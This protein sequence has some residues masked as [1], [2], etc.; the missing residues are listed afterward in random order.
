[1]A[2]KSD[3]D[4]EVIEADGN[5]NILLIAPHGV[6]GDDDNAGKLA[7]VVQKKLKCHAI[8]NEAFK[9]PE[10]DEK[11]K[12]YGE[13]DVANRLADL[14]YKPHAEE[15]PFYI[16]TITD[17]IENPGDVYV[18]WLHG[19]D[20]DNIKKEA[21]ALNK[22]DVKCLI[23]YGQP[24]EGDFSMPKEQALKFARLLT[25]RGLPAEATHDNSDNYRGVSPNNMNQY[26]KKVATELSAVKSVQLE[27]AKEGVRN[28]T[29]I[30]KAGIKIAMAISS[31]TGCEA[32]DIPE[33][34]PDEKMVNEVTERV[35][36]FIKSNHKNSIAVGRYLIE[37]FYGD[38]FN[39]AKIGKCVRGAS[40]NAMYE[41]LAKTPDAPSKSWFYN[42]INLAV[43][44]EEYKDDT[45]YQKLTLS[46]KIYLTSLN[47]DEKYFT[48]KLGL[49]KEI[50][51]KGMK[52]QA[53][54]KKIAEIK[55][56]SVI[57]AARPEEDEIPST[58]TISS[59]SPREV[60]KFRQTVE[61]KAENIKKRIEEL[62]R[63]LEKAQ[64]FIDEA[65]KC[66]SSPLKHV[67]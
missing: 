50:A 17:K 14:G 41:R 30:A 42:A 28:G 61:Q 59:M 65:D 16:K 56:K 60:E 66:L 45:D 36:E 35:I 43:D 11:S 13:P 38:D 33:E 51:T 19:I 26:F 21:E 34:H 53:L 6:P 39:K 4:I 47:K 55:G 49:I 25:E 22:P 63:E 10:K 62:N 52:I 27:F 12:K 15:H 37:K 64:K 23:G 48:A 1:M 9:K 18:F 31:L 54:L 67:A 2:K 20:D 58:D 32:Y 57:Q 7:R 29:Y 5:P 24:N 8:I 46:Q 3:R 44:D 40:F